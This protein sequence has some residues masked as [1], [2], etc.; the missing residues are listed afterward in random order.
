MKYKWLVKQLHELMQSYMKKGID[1]L[2]SENTLCQ[3]YKV[4]RQTVRLALSILEE[5]GLIEKRQGSGTYITGLSGEDGKNTIGV[6]L[7]NDQEYYY[8]QLLDDIQTSLTRQGFR[9]QAFFTNYE[10]AAE[11]KILQNLIAHPMR[12]LLVEGCKSYLP[13]PNINLYQKLIGRGTSIIFMMNSYDQLPQCPVV[14]EQNVQGSRMLIDHLIEKGH[15]SIGCIFQI[16]T[17]QGIERHQGFMDAMISHALFPEDSHICWYDTKT[18]IKL[19][20]EKDMTFIKNMTHESF[21]DCTAIV[22]QNDEIAY[23]LQ[24]ELHHQ[25]Y[26]LPGDMAIV[27]FDH[28][29]LSDSSSPTITSLSLNPQKVGIIATRLLTDTLKGLHVTSHEIPWKLHIKDSS[30]FSITY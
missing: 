26:E 23:W 12:G 29:Y 3:M 28:T 25:G 24:R 30:D 21:S 10:I 18:L 1:K 17:I 4:S 11:R 20:Q 16:D 2:P 9:M 27:S 13:N 15:S 6:I 8:P 22:C 14:K 19:E 7:P 5:E